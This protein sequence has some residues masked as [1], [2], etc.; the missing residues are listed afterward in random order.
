[1]RRFQK[2]TA[3]ITADLPAYTVVL[4]SVVNVADGMGAAVPRNINF[5]YLFFWTKNRKI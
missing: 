5:R 1:M 3:K 2:I 4:L